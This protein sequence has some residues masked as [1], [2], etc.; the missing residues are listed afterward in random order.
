VGYSSFMANSNLSDL[1]SKQYPLLI[2]VDDEDG[3]EVHRTTLDG[4]GGRREWSELLSP[5]LEQ[6]YPGKKTMR[7]EDSAG[8][9]VHEG[10]L[11]Q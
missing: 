6:R 10:K 3:R 4:P 1:E 5:D 8:K 11:G 9:T 2:T 7:V